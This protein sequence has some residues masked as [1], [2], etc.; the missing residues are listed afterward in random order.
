MIISNIKNPSIARTAYSGTSGKFQDIQ[1][2]SATFRHI[3]GHYDMLRHIQALLRHID[4]Y[5]ELC[6]T[7]AYA[8]WAPLHFFENEKSA[9][10]LGKKALIVSI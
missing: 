2:Y 7:L 1:Q 6:V 4:S 8:I 9:L 10:I 5:S 3:E